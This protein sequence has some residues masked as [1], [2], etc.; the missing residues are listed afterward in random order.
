MRGRRVICDEHD[1]IGR[2]VFKTVR[3]RPARIVADVAE[4]EPA[5][6]EQMRA[7]IGQHARAL[8]APRGIAHQP[9]RAV[10]VEHAAA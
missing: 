3:A 9:R 5:G 2:T 1:V 6:I 4:P 7:E 10:A 8:V